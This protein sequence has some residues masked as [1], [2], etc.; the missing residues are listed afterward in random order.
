MHT[1]ARLRVEND[2]ISSFGNDFAIDDISFSPVCF[3]ED[4]LTITVL[5]PIAEVVPR[6]PGWGIPGRLGR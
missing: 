6:I 5:H 1:M 3:L 2:N 4:E